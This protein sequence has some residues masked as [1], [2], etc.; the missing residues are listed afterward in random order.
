LGNTERLSLSS[1]ANTSVEATERNSLLLLLDIIE[2]ADGLLQRQVLDGGYGFEILI[3]N[4][5]TG[6]F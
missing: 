6:E 2:I 1:S 3:Y 4:I 5:H